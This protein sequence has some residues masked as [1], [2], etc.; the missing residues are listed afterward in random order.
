MIRFSFRCSRGHDFDSWFQSSAAYEAVRAQG[1]LS[2]AVCGSAEVEKALM[3]PAVSLGASEPKQTPSAEPAPA[4]KAA[5]GGAGPLRSRG[6]AE[7]AL[8]ELRR[9]VEA[10]ADYVGL[11]FAAE[12]RAMHLGDVPERAIYG[13]ASR[14]EARALIEDGVPVAPLPFLPR[15]RTN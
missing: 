5:P 14:D 11:S 2:C 4:A 6:V 15:K 8:A 9:K 10:G 7:Q 13:E 1:H 12:A 3:A